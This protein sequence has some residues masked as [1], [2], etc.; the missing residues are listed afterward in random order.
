MLSPNATCAAT[1]WEHKSNGNNNER[2]GEVDVEG[3]GV[4]AEETSE[5]TSEAP[6]AVTTVNGVELDTAA[7]GTVT[8]KF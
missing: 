3:A 8:F 4:E 2:G 7:D 6:A 5:K 1:V